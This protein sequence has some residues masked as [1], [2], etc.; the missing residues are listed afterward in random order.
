MSR[1]IIKLRKHEKCESVI[2]SHVD[3]KKIKYKNT[4][5][6]YQTSKCGTPYLEVK[7]SRN[8]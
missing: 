1:N 5:S 8:F 3:P 7:V 4:K 2:N 6:M